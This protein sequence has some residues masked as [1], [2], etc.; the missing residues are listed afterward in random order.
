MDISLPSLLDSAND[1]DVMADMP[2]RRENLHSD[3]KWRRA[4]RQFN[5]FSNKAGLIMIELTALYE[6]K[7]YRR[8]TH[9]HEREA[10]RPG[11][12]RRV[13][14]RSKGQKYQL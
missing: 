1:R 7:L 5:A 6:V 10:R 13:G 4:A 8:A 9:V 12:I 14:G 3:Q 2:E 11:S